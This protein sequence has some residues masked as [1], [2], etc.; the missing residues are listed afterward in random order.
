MVTDTDTDTD[1][2]A[3]QPSFGDRN[4]QWQAIRQGDD[5]WDMVIVGGGIIGAGIL[6]EAARLGLK[7]LLVEQRDFAWG[8]SSRS[9]KMVH[10]GLRYLGH[11][12][13]K[14]TRDSLQERERLLR[15]APGLVDR[16][17]YY[18]TLKKGQFPG[19]LPF[20]MVLSLYDWLAG[21]KNHRY[22][23]KPAV[24]QQ[25]SGIGSDGLKGAMYYTDTVTDDAR[26][27]LRVLQDAIAAGGHALNYVQAA[28]LVTTDKRVSGVLLNNVESGEQVSVRCQSVINAT[29]AWAD[30]L[31]NEVN[32][33]KRIRPLRGSHI[34]LPF[35]RLPVK[36]A[37]TLLHPEDKRPVFVFPWEGAT[38][39]GTT[40]LDHDQPLDEEPVIHDTELRYLL[41]AARILFP[42]HGLSTDDIISTWSGVRPVIGSDS[43]RDPSKERR[44]HAVWCDKGLVTVSGG[45]LTTFRLIALDAIDAALGSAARRAN[46]GGD[47]SIFIAP[48]ITPQ[49]LKTSSEQWSRR[50]I[51]RYGNHAKPLLETA[52]AAEREPLENTDFCLA[53]CRWAARNESVVHLDDLLLRRTRLGSL[54][55]RGGE[56]LFPALQQLCA[57]ELQ[58][59]AARWQSELTRYRDI[60]RRY[61]YLPHA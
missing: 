4:S 29:G 26:L 19:R 47:D 40:D 6:R 7:A 37:L 1:T 9:S 36:D 32:S 60:W 21:I 13:I 15:E 43:G 27:V 24:Q 41:E 12:D 25:F 51:G 55:P 31:R 14:L 33:E 56:S 53:E 28:S 57:E 5:T 38:V 23:S 52:P 39:I 45:K 46:T 54:L 16:M 11:G 17:G 35:E 20:G 22:F 58:W 34:V 44:D 18:F 49:A 48:D 10:G 2:P 42:D 59:D 8:T 61:Y 50:L 30:R 3:Q